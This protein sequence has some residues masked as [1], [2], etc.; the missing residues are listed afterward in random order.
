MHDD[1]L[2]NRTDPNR[3]LWPCA[4]L[5]PL[6]PFIGAALVATVGP[7]LF[8]ATGMLLV[9]VVLPL[10]DVVAGTDDRNPPDSMM[11]ELERDR[12]YRWCTYLYLPLQYGAVVFACWAWTHAAMGT[13]ERI[14]LALSVGVVSGIG[15]NAAHELGHK[16]T[17]HERAFALIALGPSFYGHFYIEHNH[18]HHLHVATPQDA[19]SS[20]FGESFWAFLPRS[21]V[22]GARGAWDYEA[23]RLRRR[24]HGPMHRGNRVL[25]SLVPS[26]VLVVVV[27]ALFGPAVLPWLALQAALA[28][29]FLESANY[30]EHYGLLRERRPD[31]TWVKVAPRHSWNSNHRFS[32]VFLYHLQ[33][34]SD[35]HANPLRRYQTLR[36]MPD[37]PQLPAGYA[38]MVLLAWVPPLWRRIMD[39]RLLDHY[40]GRI[41]LVNTGPR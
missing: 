22:G 16:R 35:H 36:S 25:V 15:I 34:H 29:V 40:D 6:S 11:R 32:N 28:V 5:V 30:L 12:W 4:L 3:L 2:V 23:A 14:G 8:W 19:A 13:P 17:S 18:G 10:V 21:I 41:E 38:A 27:V 20:R 9:V 33:R 1:S 7:G 26:V 31:G 37:A 24:G 39:P